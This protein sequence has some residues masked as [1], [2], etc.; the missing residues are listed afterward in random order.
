MC[1]HSE[2]KTKPKPSPCLCNDH[3]FCW[4]PPVLS[5]SFPLYLTPGMQAV[6]LM[7]DPNPLLWVFFQSKPEPS[8][9][10]SYH[11]HQPSLCWSVQGF[12]VG[13]NRWEGRWCGKAREGR[14]HKSE[15]CPQLST[16]DWG[17][18]W[19]FETHRFTA[20]SQFRGKFSLDEIKS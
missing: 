17:L 5:F 13:I 20:V 6:G 12:S 16:K 7:E 18:R 15:P 9:L 8:S 10:D 1:T 11:Q 19:A 3:H 2:N 14:T 4:A